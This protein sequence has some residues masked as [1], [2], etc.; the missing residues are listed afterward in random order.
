M[1]NTS[2]SRRSAFTLVELLVVIGIIAVLIG[3]LLPALSKARQQA[4]S[5]KC[6]SNLRSI[7]QALLM[8]S[9]ANRGYIYPV[10]PL[11]PYGNYSTLG[12]NV[13]PPFRWPVCAI[14]YAYPNVDP[15]NIT[16]PNVVAIINNVQLWSPPIMICPSDLDAGDAHSYMLNMHLSENPSNRLKYSSRMPNG[17]SP[18][19]VVV[20]GEKF[21]LVLDYYMETDEFD[22]TVDATRHGAQMGSNYLHLDWSVSAVSPAQAKAG[23]DPWAIVTTTQTSDPNQQNH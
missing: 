14:K 20:M 19:D 18:S 11:D 2:P 12:T 7:G 15:T 21:T 22:R 8:Y 1:V 3:V 17:Q 16:D 23:L 6:K 10:G 5:V 9:E 4:N 13:L